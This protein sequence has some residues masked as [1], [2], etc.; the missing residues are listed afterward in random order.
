MAKVE[1]F[2]D[3]VAWQKARALNKRVYEITRQGAFAR[4][5]GLSG[6][7]QRASISVMSNIGEG[8]ERGTLTEF[9]QFLSIAKSSCAE[10][11]SQIYAALDIGYIS[12][13]VFYE[14]LQQAHEVGR[15]IG[16]LHASIARKKEQKAGR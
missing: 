5:Y 7:M 16:V 9:H 4:D 1:Q 2:E 13:E 14:L 12:E 3:L 8:F 15:I 6:Q 10:V 11:R